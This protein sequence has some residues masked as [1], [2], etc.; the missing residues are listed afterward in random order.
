MKRLPN[1]IWAIVLGLALMLLVGWDL[2]S[3]LNEAKSNFQ[4]ESHNLALSDEAKIAQRLSWMQSTLDL[5]TSDRVVQTFVAA[6]GPL[7]PLAEPRVRPAFELLSESSQVLSLYVISFFAPQ[8]NDLLM[9]LH[10][11]LRKEKLLR[12][13][14]RE[15]LSQLENRAREGDGTYF[16]GP[17]FTLQGELVF[18]YSKPLSHRERVVGMVA[19]LYRVSELTNGLSPLAQRVEETAS[20]LSVN[21][22]NSD[23]ATHRL[24]QEELHPSPGWRILLN[25]P[26]AFF[27]ARD[28]VNNAFQTA[29]LQMMLVGLGMLT[30]GAIIQRKSA[31]AASKAR[32]DFMANISHEI[33]TPLN[34]VIGM[35]RLTL[36]TKLDQ[37]Q[38]EYLKTAATS[39]ESALS[40]INDLLDLSKMEAEA[41]EFAPRE[42]NLID[43]LH[44]VARTF[45]HP[46]NQKGLDLALCLGERLPETVNVDP[47]RLTQV[48]TNLLSNAV[49]FTHRGSVTLNVESIPEGLKFSV[50]DTGIGI[51]PERQSE[52]F[53]PFKQAGGEIVQEYGGTGL[54]LS[55]CRELVHRMGGRLFLE[56]QLSRG[57]H[58]SFVLPL[59]G[60]G[61]AL[62]LDGSNY[63]YFLLL[64]LP[65]ETG[66]AVRRTLQSWDLKEVDKVQSGTVILCGDPEAEVPEKQSGCHLA[67]LAAKPENLTASGFDSALLRPPHPAEL[68]RLVSGLG[69]AQT[70]EQESCPSR[71]VLLV[72]DSPINR[73][74][75]KLILEE[76]GHTVELADNG[77]EA[78]KKASGDEFDLVL[79]DLHMPEMDGL[80]AA[81]SLRSS[82]CQ[83]PII[84]L[85]G[86]IQNSD[87]E[88]CLA[89]GM[90]SHLPKPLDEQRL[91]TAIDSLFEDKT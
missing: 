64:N 85:T 21:L 70:E 29:L 69:N 22:L 42:T 35:T 89:A 72:D 51:S 65:A 14:E 67:L 3:S 37:I 80:Q 76:M 47:L 24:Y 57:S 4:K 2:W 81:R 19:C 20:K 77:S 53:E 83:T 87:R 40:L 43:L 66:R 15:Q 27:W 75:G 86:K 54:G 60:E 50:H 56:S 34:G 88:N 9:A 73:N 82:G 59:S 74:L 10:S 68:L 17:A 25:R 23:S 41:L 11:P 30:T 33:R 28:D 49:K 71:R 5:T 1:Y 16:A 39:A 18:F 8:N 46:A 79:M 12:P 32:S 63:P 13:E 38:E 90:N 58:F 84:A 26:D 52:I 36:K 44:R 7:P 62:K 31:M 78:V 55:I 91:K 45:Q 61:Q 6:G 48:L